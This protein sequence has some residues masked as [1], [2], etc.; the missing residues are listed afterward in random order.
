MDLVRGSP[1]LLTGRLRNRLRGLENECTPSR[2]TFT[3]GHI[4][5]W[6]LSHADAEGI[7]KADAAGFSELILPD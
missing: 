3:R 5:Q 1:A 4:L 7:G 2:F 6:V